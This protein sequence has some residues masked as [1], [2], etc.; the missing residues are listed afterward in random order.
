MNN[1]FSAVREAS[2]GSR[3]R[4]IVD[5]H[6]AA[7]RRWYQAE[8][9]AARPD[10]LTCRKAVDDHMPE[11]LGLYDELVEL[12]GGGDTFARFLSLFCPPPYFSGCSQAVWQEDGGEPMMI[13]NYDYHPALLEGTLLCTRWLGRKVIAMSDCLWGVLD[14]MNEDGLTVSLTFGGRTQTGVGFGIP[15]ILRYILETCTTVAEASAVLSR[16]P[17]SM[18]Y[19]VTILEK[20]GHFKTAHVAP[21]RMPV[22][23]SFPIATN[24]QGSPEWAAHARATASLE[25]EHFLM[26]RFADSHE[27]AEGFAK[28]FLRHPLRTEQFDRGWGTL[29]TA[30]YWPASGEMAL[31]WPSFEWRQSF[32]Y[33]K[34]RT[35]TQSWPRA[36]KRRRVSL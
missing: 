23:R 32:A 1:T 29:Y 8:G 15:V 31:Q 3:W 11:I 21:D 17:T 20:S 18:S 14:G 30:A 2:P 16:V 19:N 7:Y 22:F 4:S 25:R 5:D 24:H 26:S 9:D 35:H 33:F 34:E 6:W 27:T 10:Y 13:R 28:A 36:S 12:G